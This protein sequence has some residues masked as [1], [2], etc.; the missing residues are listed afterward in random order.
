M[1]R[2]PRPA[3]LLLVLA[4]NDS[5]APHSVPKVPAAP[6]AIHKIQHVV[7][8]MQENRSFDSYF[9]TFPGAEGIP[10]LSGAPGGVRAGLRAGQVR[11]AFSRLGG[12]EP[13]RTPCSGRRLHGHRRRADGRVHLAGREEDGHHLQR[14]GVAALPGHRPDRCHGIP[15]PARDP[16]LLGVRHELRAAGSHVRAQRV[17]EPA[18]APLHGVGVVGQMQPGGQP[19]ELH[20]RAR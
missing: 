20:Q 13:R 5:N 15:R 18:R 10:M 7:V 17:L 1:S 4:C 8:I 12:P 6:A 14:G 2:L 9:G 16:E 3:F 11:H 19:H